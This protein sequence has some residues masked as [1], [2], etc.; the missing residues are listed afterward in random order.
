MLFSPVFTGVLFVV[1]I[2]AMAVATFIENDFGADSA[3]QLIYNARWFE[4]IF[5]L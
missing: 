4:L 2:V 3:R 5:L 1:F